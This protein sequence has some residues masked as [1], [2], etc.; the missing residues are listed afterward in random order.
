MNIEPNAIIH[1]HFQK[2]SHPDNMQSGIQ[3]G[4]KVEV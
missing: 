4:Y 2:N 3:L 1:E